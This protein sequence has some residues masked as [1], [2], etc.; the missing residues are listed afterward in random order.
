MSRG[1]GR[2]ERTIQEAIR[3]DETSEIGVLISSWHV[4]GDLF[5]PGYATNEHLSWEPSR[6]QQAAVARAMRS[7][8]RKFPRFALMGGQGRKRLFLYDTTDPD[9][10]AWAQANLAS[11]T[12][13]PY[14]NRHNVASNARTCARGVARE[15]RVVSA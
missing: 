4:V 11:R 5:H 6:T 3:R 9:S 14:C 15:T 10:V 1:L 12:P 2:I 7:F 8:V 13:V